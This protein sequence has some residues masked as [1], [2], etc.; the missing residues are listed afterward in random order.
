MNIK[1]SAAGGGLSQCIPLTPFSLGLTGD[2][3]AIMNAHNLA[4]VALTSRIQHEFNY[5]D[6]ELAK[7]DLKRLNIDP[8]RIELKWIMDFCAQALRK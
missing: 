7:R 5:N 4:M 3:N 8:D 2:I 6:E 1:G